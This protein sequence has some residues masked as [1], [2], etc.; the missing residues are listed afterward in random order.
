MN[1]LSCEPLSGLCFVTVNTGVGMGR[2]AGQK[3]EGVFDVGCGVYAVIQC[4]GDMAAR[5]RLWWPVASEQQS[6]GG[7]AVA[8]GA[9]KKQPPALTCEFLQVSGRRLLL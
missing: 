5:T 8:E 9:L 7:Q 1:T 4:Y 2:L 3:S 6:A